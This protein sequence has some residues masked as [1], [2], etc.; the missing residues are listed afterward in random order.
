MMRLST[1]LVLIALASATMTVETE[2]LA[3]V[4]R[5]VRQNV[6][7]KLTGNTD[8]AVAFAAKK[9]ITVRPV[10]SSS[11]AEES[12]SL[13]TKELVS[14]ADF[15]AD[16]YRKQMRDLVYERSMERFAQ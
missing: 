10:V 2:G 14:F 5:S 7:G 3:S 8:G 6:W 4:V 15:D 12:E 9:V 16:T 13:D 1:V 11:S